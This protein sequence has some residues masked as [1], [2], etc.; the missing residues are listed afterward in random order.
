M[1]KI[2]QFFYSLGMSMLNFLP[3]NVFGNKIRGQFLKKFLKNKPNNLQVSKNTN[4]INPWNIY[5]G[6][7][8]FIGFGVWINPIKLVHI[9]DEV[10]IGP[11]CCISAG[12]HTS[13]NGSYRYGIHDSEEIYIG[14]GTWLAAHTVITK[15]SKIPR[16]TCVASGAIGNNFDEN[17]NS[18]YVGI[19]LKRKSEDK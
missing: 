10:I 17:E 16:G 15:G 19:P 2:A 11:Y 4:L 5:I 6:D 13:K 1:K 9:N 18:I 14:F 3:D 8:V 7:N 12:N